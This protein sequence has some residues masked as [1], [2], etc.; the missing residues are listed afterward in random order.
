[1]P[2]VD[3]R[4]AALEAMAREPQAVRI[5]ESGQNK[6]KDAKIEISDSIRPNECGHSHTLRR[7]GVASV[8][9]DKFP[10]NG[11]QSSHDDGASVTT[12]PSGSAQ[13]ALSLKADISSESD[14]SG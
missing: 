9:G 3:S 12:S 13:S 8:V 6:S 14:C 7:L 5:G 10:E 1:M 4:V 11:N 2:T